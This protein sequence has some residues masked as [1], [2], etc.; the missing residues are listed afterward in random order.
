MSSTTTFCQSV[1]LGGLEYL[2][3]LRQVGGERVSVELAAGP[4]A[5]TMAMWQEEGVEEEAL[6][7]F[8]DAWRHGTSARLA[9]LVVARGLVDPGS[10]L[11]PEAVVPAVLD[12]LEEQ[13]AALGDHFLQLLSHFELL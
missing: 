11:Q 7:A 1:E 9:Q 10:G 6:V 4:R 5:V 8:I 3:T 2:V 13:I 12:I